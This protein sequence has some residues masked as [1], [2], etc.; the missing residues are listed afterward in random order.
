MNNQIDATITGIYLG[1][2]QV[3]DE[4]NFIPLR[5]LT[6]F[7]GPNSSGK[8]AIE[9]ALYLIE[10]EFF[11]GGTLAEYRKSSLISHDN[12]Q[13]LNEHWR[14][15]SEALDSYAPACTLGFQSVSNCHLIDQLETSRFPL[16]RSPSKYANDALREYE[17]KSGDTHQ[18]SSLRIWICR[19]RSKFRGRMAVRLAKRQETGLVRA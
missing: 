6:F 1:G 5:R 3:F 16:C 15:N 17:S 7:Y 13:L 11:W 18:S 9:D 19:N 4:V 8:S 12:A 2:F 10:K 14:R